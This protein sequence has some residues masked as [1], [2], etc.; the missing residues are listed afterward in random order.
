MYAGRTCGIT[1]IH[2]SDYMDAH[3]LTDDDVAAALGRT[4]STVSRIRRRKMRPDW[5]TIE[6]IQEFTGGQVTAND[7]VKI[8]PAQ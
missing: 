7:F 1:M 6:K 5:E 4:R 2:L 3:N 8:E